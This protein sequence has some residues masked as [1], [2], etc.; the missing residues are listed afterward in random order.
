MDNL[1]EFIAKFNRLYHEV[2]GRPPAE[3]AWIW[4]HTLGAVLSDWSEE[5]Y[6]CG[7]CE[8]VIQERL[9]Q[10]RRHVKYGGSD[11]APTTADDFVFAALY[12]RAGCM[13]T[14]DDI[15]PTRYVPTV[16]DVNAGI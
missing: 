1:T 8:E 15:G 13:V 5:N 16:W 4:A 10:A 14:L 7:W 12:D 11:D 6:S 2:T 3:D 9:R